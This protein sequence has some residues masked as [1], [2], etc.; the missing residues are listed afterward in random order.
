MKFADLNK[1]TI[2]E[3]KNEN[4][5]V[6]TKLKKKKNNWILLRA[7]VICNFFQL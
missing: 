4:T 2:A 7:E 5:L 3:F 1:Y 6:V